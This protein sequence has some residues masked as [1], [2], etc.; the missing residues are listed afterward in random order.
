MYLR[1]LEIHGFKSF[2]RKTKLE[3]G[4][5]VTAV[6]GPN[7]TGKS[8]VADAI[9]WAMGEQSMR[10]LRG[11]RTEDVIFGGSSGRSRSGMAQVTVTFENSDNWL[12][13]DFDE[14]GISRRAYRSGENE[15]RLNGSTVR[16]KDIQDLLRS[17]GIALGGSMVI[18]QGEVDAALS[19][20]PEHRRLLLEEGA[21]VSRYYARRDDARRR[22]DRTERNLQRLDDLH[23]ELGPRL[24]LLREQA[25]VAERSGELAGDLQDKSRALLAHRLALAIGARENSATAHAE[26]KARLEEFEARDGPE[27]S[28]VADEQVAAAAATTAAAVA[29]HEELRARLN[30]LTAAARWAEQRAELEDRALADRETRLA[31]AVEAGAGAV[32]VVEQLQTDVAAL[33]TACRELEDEVSA[34]GPAGASE[35]SIDELEAAVAEARKVATDLAGEITRIQESQRSLTARQAENDNAAANAA[36]DVQTSAAAVVTQQAEAVEAERRVHDAEARSVEARTVRDRAAARVRAMRSELERAGA[37]TIEQRA[38]LEAM[39][40]ESQAVATAGAESMATRQ[41]ILALL[42]NADQ[43]RLRGLLRTGLLTIPPEFAAAVDAAL[44]DLFQDVVIDRIEDLGTAITF[45]RDQPGTRVRFRPAAGITGPSG[46]RWPFGGGPPDDDGIVGT[47]DGLIQVRPEYDDAL[48]PLLQAIVV[49]DDL[50]TAIGLRTG[51]RDIG[52][53]QLVTRD[54]ELVDHDGSVLVGRR[55]EEDSTDF[56]ARAAE[57][58]SAIA[59]AEPRLAT[60]VETEQIAREALESAVTEEE[61]AGED[62]EAAMLFDAGSRSGH[63]SAQEELNLANRQLAFWEALVVRT[64]E[65]AEEITN[66]QELARHGLAESQP[67]IAPC[68]EAVEIAEARL[69]AARQLASE[70]GIAELRSCLLIERERLEGTRV[71]LQNQQS[72]AEAAVSD[73][74]RAEE[75]ITATRARV[76]AARAEAETFQTESA[77]IGEQLP[78]LAEDV[79][80]RRREA[81]EL[82]MAR[83]QADLLR[84]SREVERGEIDNAVRA[85]A[86]R[87]EFADQRIADIRD[88]IRQELGVEDLEPRRY[89]RPVG[90]LEAEIERLQRLVYDIGPVNPMAPQQ[91]EDESNQFKTLGEEIVD[92]EQT[93]EELRKLTRELE[94]AVQDEFMR[95]FDLIRSEFRKYFRML[96]GGGDASLELTDPED[97][98]TSGLEITA[99]LPGKRAQRLEALSG[100][101]R[102]LVSVALLFAMFSARPGPI[103]VLDEVDAALDEANTER[104]RHILHDFA[105]RTQFIVITHNPGTIEEADS[106]LGVSMSANGVSELVSVRMNGVDGNG[107]AAPVEIPSAG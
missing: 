56:A 79:E 35:E 103:C 50:D 73:Q 45:L 28:T 25:E 3:F 61:R 63:H 37:D 48:T 30:D 62:L 42:E 38:A 43:L 105:Q 47:L 52:C 106:I 51:D 100:G 84:R 5:G 67:R 92:M 71:R 6:I 89:S 85:A 81:S 32:A 87:T 69:A 4:T 44:G 46:R 102:S 27:E 8:N 1:E 99:K 82:E 70:S 7:G 40:A 74:A 54:G 18:G 17:G 15:Y 68:R 33:E 49:V 31:A 95:T 53:Y 11:S 72:L 59:T 14:V 34:A 65:T 98:A 57:L 20:R 58:E 41:G 13:I 90:E 16:L 10:S 86:D 96:F 66:R 60:A 29:A 77:E 21:G 94:T 19:L 80:T 107:A 12:P 23:S 22:L 39:R 9:R 88:R 93:V 75:D 83:G 64:A 101:E 97:P 76:E 24:E 26:A 55:D 78:A 91:F 104:F 2:A 36:E